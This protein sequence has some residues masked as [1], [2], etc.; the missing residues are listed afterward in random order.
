ME[1]SQN[2]ITL[3]NSSPFVYTNCTHLPLKVT[4]LATPAKENSS[5]LRSS[6][7][8]QGATEGGS[9]AL[10]KLYAKTVL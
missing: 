6:N 2:Q 8:A 4:G 9:K 7:I 10:A 5:C 1:A 3:N